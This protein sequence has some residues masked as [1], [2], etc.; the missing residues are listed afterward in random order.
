MSNSFWKGGNTAATQNRPM[1]NLNNMTPTQKSS[2]QL[3]Y[4][5]GTKKK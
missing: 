3:G 2:T 4:G 5:A 1:P